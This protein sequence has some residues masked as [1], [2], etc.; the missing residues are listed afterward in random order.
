MTS[1]ATLRNFAELGR[2]SNLP[3]IITNVLTGCAIGVATVPPHEWN[4]LIVIAICIAIACFYTAGMALNDLADAAIDR[5]ERP[6]RPIPSGRVS[7]RHAATFIAI[8]FAIG[9]IILGII[10][11]PALL[12]AGIL[13]GLIVAYDLIHALTPASVILMGACRGMV[14]VTAAAAM[15]R[16]LSLEW[17]TI[18]IFAGALTIYTILFS[19]IARSETQQQLDRR[20]WLAILIPVIVLAP[21][22]LA[23]PARWWW[24]IIAMCALLAWLSR[25]VGHVFASPPRTRQAVMTWLSGFC[26]IDAFYLTLLDAPLLALIAAIAFGLT[27]IGHR[28][29]AG[30]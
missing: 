3:T 9:L 4:V 30:T 24:M 11:M 7:P 18:T 5:E 17:R 12:M 14:Y 28:R 6:A 16:A 8:L 29:I 19:V 25:A 21:L 27:V 26:L 20:K 22:A 2:V 10:S 13:V 23:W 15:H 1:A